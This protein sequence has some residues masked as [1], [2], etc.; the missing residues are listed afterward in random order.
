MS[1]FHEQVRALLERSGSTKSHAYDL[2]KRRDREE[3]RA[4]FTE[5]RMQQHIM[6]VIRI[7]AS[8]ACTVLALE[9]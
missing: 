8:E 2:R 9:R 7:A 1:I 3:I 5:P 4:R 6:V